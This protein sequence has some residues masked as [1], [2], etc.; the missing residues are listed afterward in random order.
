MKKFI[1]LS[2]VLIAGMFIMGCGA[3]TS[4]T[5]AT[6][7]VPAA[8]LAGNV[9]NI[10]VIGLGIDDNIT[11]LKGVAGSG[12]KAN[13]VTPTRVS[14]WWTAVDSTSKDNYSYAYRFRMYDTNAN[15]LT[16]EASLAAATSSTISTLE[17]YTSLEVTSALL[18]FS[19]SLGTSTSAP[20]QFLNYNSSTNKK[21]NG[22]LTYTATSSGTS[23]TV[24]L[25]YANLT[26]GAIYPTGSASFSVNIDGET[27]AGTVT[28]DGTSSATLTFTSGATGT[29]TL[30]LTDGS[31]TASSL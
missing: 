11:G 26:L 17:T 20:L 13:T 28:Y 19:M 27:V 23:Y 5:S 31:A 18:S 22:P 14:G 15:E 25:T 8:T 29:Y 1:I 3:S 9:G 21:I 12:V 7:T 24:T 2:L 6:P 30:N 10:G 4:S 16:T